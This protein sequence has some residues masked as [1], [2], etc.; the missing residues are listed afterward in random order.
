MIGRYDPE[1]PG[2]PLS[3]IIKVTG[4]GQ[5]N[6]EW[7][8]SP[9]DHKV[10]LEQNLK[11]V[12]MIMQSLITLKYKVKCPVGRFTYNA[13]DFFTHAG[14]LSP[15]RPRHVALPYPGLDRWLRFAVCG[16]T[17]V[18]EVDG[19]LHFTSMLQYIT[20]WMSRLSEV[21]RI[22]SRNILCSL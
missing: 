15:D 22:S 9:V 19:V 6:H 20:G 11:S 3:P 14:L 5:T 10:A 21:D 12:G 1:T 7:R 16:I 4:L 18:G 8:H 17:A 13:V 2:H